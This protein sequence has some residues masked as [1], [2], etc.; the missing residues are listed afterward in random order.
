[1][2][3]EW[4]EVKYRTNLVKHGVDFHETARFSWDRALIIDRSRHG[5]GEPRFGAIGP[6]QGKLHTIVFTWRG[7][8]MRIISFRRANAKEAKAYE[9]QAI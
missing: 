9:T 7:T 3:Y 6:Y 2:E 4:D 8:V 1:M 5:D